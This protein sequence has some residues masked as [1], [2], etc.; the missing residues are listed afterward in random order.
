MVLAEEIYW[1]E[2]QGENLMSATKMHWDA[3]YN[4]KNVNSVFLCVSD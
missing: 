3:F 4:E 1:L 2:W